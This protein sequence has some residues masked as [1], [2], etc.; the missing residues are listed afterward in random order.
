MSSARETV[1]SMK[2]NPQSVPVPGNSTNIRTGIAVVAHASQ[3]EQSNYH[4]DSGMYAHKNGGTIS[5]S[6]PDN[7]Y[8]SSN[9]VHC[10]AGGRIPDQMNYGVKLDSKHHDAA[11]SYS[12][13]PNGHA[14]TAMPA[15]DTADNGLATS[16]P[17]GATNNVKDT[18]QKKRRKKEK[19]APKRPL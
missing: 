6:N 19:E 14:T 8:N 9:A 4:Y 15:F 12:V 13:P 2:K 16:V 10:R 11:T 5:S 18:N 3:Y 17:A 7:L 1:P